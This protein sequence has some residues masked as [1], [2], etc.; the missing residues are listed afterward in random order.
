MN[1]YASVKK[2]KKHKKFITNFVF[3]INIYK[4]AVKFASDTW[5]KLY[6]KLFTSTFMLLYIR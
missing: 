2:K 6:V 3:K 4:K 1:K 5:K